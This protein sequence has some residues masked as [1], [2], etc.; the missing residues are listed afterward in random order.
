MDKHMVMVLQ[1][2]FLLYFGFVS[3]VIGK[4]AHFVSGGGI[5][6]MLNF[7]HS[8]LGRWEYLSALQYDMGFQ[9][10]HTQGEEYSVGRMLDCGPKGYEFE[11]H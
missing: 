5:S 8:I 4:G 6:Y 7:Q 9:C 11:S 2:W 10:L 3:F 1:M